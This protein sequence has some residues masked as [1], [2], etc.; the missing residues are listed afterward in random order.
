MYLAARKA[1]P[2][3][4]SL[5]TAALMFPV[6]AVEYFTS[7][8]QYGAEAAAVALILW[9]AQGRW[10][11]LAVAL[12]LLMPL[13]YPLAFLIP[14]LVFYVWVRDGRRPAQTIAA[15]SAAMLA[16]LYIFF[17]QPNTSPSLWRYWSTSDATS[18][19][20]AVSAIAFCAWALRKKD[21]FLLACALPALL[22]SIAQF[23]HWYP[24]SPRTS[25][26]IRP[27]LI[28]SAVVVLRNVPIRFAAVPAVAWALFTAATYKPEPFEDYP[29]AIAYLR[30]HVKPG[31]MLLVHADARE[32]FRFYA[33]DMAPDM[34]PRAT[35]GSTGWPC[36][37]RSWNAAPGSSKESYVRADLDRLVPR[38]FHGTVWL[39]YANRPLHWKY[40]GLDEGDLWRRYLWDRGCPPGKYVDLPNL[41]ISPA[42]CGAM[43]R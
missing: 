37:T 14:G 42:Q 25:L 36:C 11:I 16:V 31:D 9:A 35:F 28:L 7:F 2:Q 34:M 43:T 21:G 15:V 24:A 4:A 27:C 8:K 3:W 39:F 20:L 19:P 18:W 17:I 1:A 41:V 29:A 33:P 5:A 40:I 13:A 23:L 22:L 6:L 12:L 10:Q 32:G 38:D 26:F 30:E